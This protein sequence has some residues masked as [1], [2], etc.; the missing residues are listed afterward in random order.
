MEKVQR[1]SIDKKN[2][3]KFSKNDESSTLPPVLRLQNI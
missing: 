2:G 1:N 3:F